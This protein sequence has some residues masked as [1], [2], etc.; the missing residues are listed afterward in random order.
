VGTVSHLR[1]REVV[2][3]CGPDAEAVRAALHGAL[4]L[5]V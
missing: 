3:V 1:N 2:F 5:A 4:P